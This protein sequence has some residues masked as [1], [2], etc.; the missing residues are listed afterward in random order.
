MAKR[1]SLKAHMCGF[2]LE[3]SLAWEGWGLGLCAWIQLLSRDHRK[4]GREQMCTPHLPSWG[5]SSSPHD[6]ADVHQHTGPAPS[7]MS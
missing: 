4:E 7:Q 2:A 6:L 1:A 5:P 3:H